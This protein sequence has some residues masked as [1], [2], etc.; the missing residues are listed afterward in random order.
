MPQKR[1]LLI[2][3]NEDIR[4]GIKCLLEMEGYAISEAPHAEGGLEVLSKSPLPSLIILDYMMPGMG[5]ANFLN[6]IRK[7]SPLKDV[8]VLV[9]TAA[10][11]IG[12]G[13]LADATVMSKPLDFDKFIGSIRTLCAR[14]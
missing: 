4:G 6:E 7:H 11:V 10:N 12:N 5:G 9:I 8:P 1:I 3:D 2:E 14:T 13:V